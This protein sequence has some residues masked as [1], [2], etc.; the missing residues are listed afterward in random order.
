[1]LTAGAY[2]RQCCNVVLSAC[3]VVYLLYM[4]G[5]CAHERATTTIF[6]R[7]VRTEQASYSEPLPEMVLSTPAGKKTSSARQASYSARIELK[8]RP[9]VPDGLPASTYLAFWLKVLVR[10][11]TIQNRR[12]FHK[13][14]YAVYIYAGLGAYKIFPSFFVS[15][16]RG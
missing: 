2:G 9:Q 13:Y 1:M 4:S 5:L 14:T 15:Y 8:P 7:Y 10:T 11:D 6:Y 12:N 16:R 3:S